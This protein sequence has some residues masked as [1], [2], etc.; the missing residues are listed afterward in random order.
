MLNIVVPMAGRGSRFAAVGWDIPKP[1]IP[2]HGRAMIEV[3]VNNLRPS[4]DHRFVF[5][6]QRTHILDY[7]LPALLERVAPNCSVIPVDGVTAGPACSVLLA[8]DQIDN[9]DPLMIANCDQWID[10]DIDEYLSYAPSAANSGLIMTMTAQSP[11]WSFIRRDADHRVVEVVEKQVVSNEA[12]TG[13]YHFARG[14]DFVSAAA[15]MIRRDERV[16]GEFYVAPVYNRLLARSGL[17]RTFCVGTDENGMFGL[18]TPEDLERFL[19]LD[20]AHR[21]QAEQNRFKRAA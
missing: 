14:K 13:V 9:D 16:N 19:R 12:T 17:I 3:V 20:F 21:L 1:L 8:V 10:C 5:I 11:K 6:C 2:V 4:R 18:G 15:E 7:R